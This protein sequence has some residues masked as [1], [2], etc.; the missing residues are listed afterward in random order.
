MIVL[1]DMENA[2]LGYGANE[3]VKQL[4]EGRMLFIFEDLSEQKV[5][6][7]PMQVLRDY[8]KKLNEDE[9]YMFIN[10]DITKVKTVVC[11][12]SEKKN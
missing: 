5:V 11:R 3:V 9:A 2:S 8:K 7:V 4:K 1:S 6:D 12:K 10:N